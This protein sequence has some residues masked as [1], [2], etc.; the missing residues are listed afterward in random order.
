MGVSPEHGPDLPETPPKGPTQEEDAYTDALKGTGIP[1]QIAHKG[2]AMKRTMA[3]V[4]VG[5]ILLNGILGLF[6]EVF[7]IYLGDA[8]LGW[9]AGASGFVAALILF[10]Q[11]LLLIEKWLPGLEKIGLGTG[12][13]AE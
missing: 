11:R 4:I 13:E 12:V 3:V 9:I 10:L 5:L 7:G 1:T 2:Q 6:V 8:H